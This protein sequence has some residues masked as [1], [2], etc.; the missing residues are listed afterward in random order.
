[1]LLTMAVT[2]QDL[3]RA[4]QDLDPNKFTRHAFH[5]TSCYENFTWSSA[6]QRAHALGKLISSLISGRMVLSIDK[7]LLP[8]FNTFASCATVPLRGEHR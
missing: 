3:L 1:M 8:E 5:P 7:L 2:G 4:R 6:E